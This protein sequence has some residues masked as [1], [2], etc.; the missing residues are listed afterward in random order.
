MTY[1]DRAA[2]LGMYRQN[3]QAEAAA[4]SKIPL[5]CRAVAFVGCY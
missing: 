2:I 1:T 4:T 5:E 3:L